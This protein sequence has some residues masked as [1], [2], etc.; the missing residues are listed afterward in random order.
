MNVYTLL[1]L[2]GGVIIGLVVGTLPG[3][4]DN[5][6]IAV[7]IPI[8]FG[9]EPQHGLCLLVGIYCAT[10][11]GGSF[12]AILLNIPG[13]ASSVVTTFDGYPMAKNGLAGQ[14][15]GI[16]TVSSV[17][18]GVI[19]GFTL[20]LFAP[21]LAQQALKF[22]PTE[23]FS[24]II[25]GFCTVIGM[26]TGNIIKSMIAVIIGLFIST[27]GMSPQ[28]GES[29]FTFGNANLLDGIPLVTL[30]IGLFGVTAVFEM[31]FEV[32]TKKSNK[33][34]EVGRIWP[35]KKLFKRILPTTLISGTMGTVV[36]IL[37]G[38]GMIMA[39]YLAYDTTV[40]RLK[41]KVKN[42][43]QG[44]PEGVAAPESANN[45]VV[46]S[47]MIPLIS[48]GIPGNSVSALFI[49]ALMIHGLQ[50]G[51]ALFKDAP[52]ISYLL[53]VSFLAAYVFI[54]PLGLLMA[55][56]LTTTI[57]KV[58]KNLLGA[59]VIVLC[60]TGAFAFKNSLFD[61]WIIIIFGVIGFIF[62]RLNIPFSALILAVVLG[63]LLEKSYHQS[64][65]LSNGSFA[66]FFEKPISLT[67]LIV[68]LL[69]VTWPIITG[70]RKKEPIT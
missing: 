45:A 51:P 60:F 39:I 63:K 52:E 35:D 8:T 42:F 29:R 68:S 4:N 53:L 54:L 19:S 17:I 16:S 14:A 48:L 20:L 12:P 10:C 36:G 40:R 30:M 66:I 61:F 23:Y 27:I 70:F 65:V 49:G 56:F 62:N 67:L 64:M 11:F 6:T 46:A 2:V 1:F 21:I 5:I 3:M 38:A 32:V 18:G 44:A 58:P 13:T 25:L 57:L 26:A 47:S 37:P 69:F 50:P 28:T 34:M 7:L 24:L 55:K 9:M 43:G 15:L 22:G 59:T 33:K 41:N 31:I